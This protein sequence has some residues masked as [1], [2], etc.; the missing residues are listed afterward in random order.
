MGC[1]MDP[2]LLRFAVAAA[3]SALSTD[4]EIVGIGQVLGAHHLGDEERRGEAMGRRREA[5][6]EE[7]KAIEQVYRRMGLATTATAHSLI[8]NANRICALNSDDPHISLHPL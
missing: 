5:S 6:E 7:R 8:G 1:S 4:D 2:P 3:L